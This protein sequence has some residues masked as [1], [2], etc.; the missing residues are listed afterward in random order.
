MNM[1]LYPNGKAGYPECALFLQMPHAL[2][3]LNLYK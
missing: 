3:R 1:K 2:T